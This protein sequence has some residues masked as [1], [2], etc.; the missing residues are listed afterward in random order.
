MNKDK[1][2]PQHVLLHFGAYGLSSLTEMQISQQR[3]HLL[4]GYFKTLMFVRSGARDLGLPH[5]RPALHNMS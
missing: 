1:S 4:L 3:Q 5:G 2:R